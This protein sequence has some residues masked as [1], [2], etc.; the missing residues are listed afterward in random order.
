MPL[1]TKTEEVTSVRITAAFASC[2]LL[3]GC[4]IPGMSVP[5]VED[6]AGESPIIPGLAL[7]S[8]PYRL[9]Q[10]C[11]GWA[12]R[13]VMVGN[14]PFGVAGSKDGTIVLLMDTPVAILA[15]QLTI[16]NKAHNEA[17]NENYRALRKFLDSKSIAVKRVRPLRT[18]DGRIEGYFLELGSDGYSLVKELSAP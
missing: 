7:C 6:A 5:V 14:R 13:K 1:S 12:T 15:P 4:A 8:K 18:I 2:L 17:M 10:D 16:A 9:E 3:L 11:D